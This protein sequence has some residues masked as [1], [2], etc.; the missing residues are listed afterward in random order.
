MNQQTYKLLHMVL[1]APSVNHT[2]A[3]LASLMQVS[4]RSVRYYIQSILLFLSDN[5]YDEYVSFTE[6]GLVYSGSKDIAD[7]ILEVAS[8]NDFYLYRLSSKERVLIIL[9]KLLLSDTF[10]NITDIAKQLDVSRTT[11]IKDME[12]VKDYINSL[13]LSLNPST[14]KGYLISASESKRQEA[15]FYL[16]HG[17]LIPGSNNNNVCLRYLR[18]NYHDYPSY[19]SVKPILIESEGKYHLE[20]SDNCFKEI[21]I[22]LSIL[23]LRLKSGNHT[24]YRTKDNSS[25]SIE[26]ATDILESA[27]RFFNLTYEDGDVFFLAHHLRICRFDTYILAGDSGNLR[28]HLSLLSFLKATLSELNIPFDSED[29]IW[30]Q[31]EKHLSDIDKAHKEG[32]ILTNEYT[33]KM[34][35]EYSMYYDAICR[36]LDILENCLEYQYTRDDRAVILIYITVAAEK[37]WGDRLMPRIIVVCHLGIG[38][39]NF[40]AEK[41]RNSFSVKIL[42]VTSSHKLHDILDKD[43]CDLIVSTIHLDTPGPPWILV[44]PVLTDDNIISLQRFFTEIKSSHKPD[45]LP[46]KTESAA[47]Q[48]QFTISDSFVMLDKECASSVDAIRCSASPLIENNY[49]EKIY[50]DK[51]IESYEDSGAYFVYC[52]EVALAH[53]SPD[54]GVNRFG[55]TILRLANPIEFGS[56][57]NDPVKFVICMASSNDSIYV[58]EILNIMNLFGTKD[59]RDKAAK[60][61]SSKELVDLIYSNKN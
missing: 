4:T 59:F 55:L 38:T 56:D 35:N 16:L 31:L 58:N 7:E 41:L 22:I 50:V 30:K 49:I 19:E 34:I 42:A 51:M 37:Y 20:V 45:S 44:S 2:V 32:K 3:N 28:F 10:C 8:G 15:L 61:T 17:N 52:P 53:A 36:N 11:I 27:A 5:N 33:S 43:N 47:V 40:L 26:I 46:A 24:S 6:K 13:E 48:S 18:D 54:D 21:E 29:Y 1:N 9:L 39:A 57:A 60:V 14:N 23:V 25:S 12:S